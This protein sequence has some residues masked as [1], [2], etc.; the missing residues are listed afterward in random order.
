[1]STG[2]VLILHLAS[3]DEIGTSRLMND[4]LYLNGANLRRGAVAEEH[5]MAL[6]CHALYLSHTLRST[7]NY[8]T[9]H[10]KIDTL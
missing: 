8:E 7:P 5:E 3:A 6:Q 9:L 1:M 2:L 4:M 10:R